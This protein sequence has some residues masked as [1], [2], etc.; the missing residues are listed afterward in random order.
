MTDRPSNLIIRA[1]AGTGK[2]FQLSNRFLE[3][4][5]R[6]VPVDRILATTFTRKAA[7]EILDRVLFRLARAATDKKDREELARFIEIPA[8]GTDECF[9]LL[10]RA[11]RNLH[12]MRVST[13][14][15]FFAQIATS[16]SLELGLPPGW[17]ICEELDDDRMRTQ[18]I[19]TVLGS[20]KEL[21]QLT[22]LL[23]KGE[24][25]RGIHQ[26]VR[27]CVDQLYQL[28]LETEEPAWQ[29]LP[30][31]KPL[32]NVQLAA[33]LDDLRAVALPN[34]KRFTAAR[35]AD[36]ERAAAGD[37]ETFI[38]KGIAA[39]VLDNS[40]QY[41]GKPIPDEVAD[42][43][44]E[45]LHQA[46][47]EIVGR[48]ARQTE[49][50]YQLLD[51]F[52]ESYRQL[53]TG[54]G[55]L[56]FDD[57]TDFLARQQ[58]AGGVD[59]LAFRL[60]SRMDHL[61]LDEFQ[62]TSLAQWQVIR[63][64]AK[65][66]AAMPEGSFFCVGDVK[67]AI[68]GW[69]GGIAEIFDA[70]PRELSD[71]TYG[72][73]DVSYRSAAPVIDTVNAVF[74]TMERHPNLARGENEVRRWCA[75]FKK[76]STARNDL[77]GFARL[78]TSPDPAE[79]ERA[80]D[81]VLAYAAQ[82]VAD[83]TAKAPGFSIGVLVRTNDAV[84]RLI[85]LL[86]KMRVNASEEGGN[87][88]TDS[89]AVRT[90]SSLLKLADHP[91]DTVART[92][93][94]HSPLGRVLE[95]EDA[96]DTAAAVLLSQRVRRRLVEQGYGPAVYDFSRPLLPGCNRREL[97]RLTQ[98]V[99][100]AYGYQSAVTLRPT[101]F[102]RLVE[103]QRV[104]DPTA[105]DVRVMTVHQSKG[106]QF[107][108]VV[109]PDL[110]VDLIGQSGAFVVD[111]ADPISPVRGVCLYVNEHV[112]RLMPQHIQQMFQ[113]A[114]DRAVGESLCVLYVA[115]TRASHALHMIVAPSKTNERKLRRTFAGL[116]R[117]TLADTQRAPA[118]MN[119]YETGDPEWFTRVGQ[120]RAEP[121][122]TPPL[123]AAATHEPLP[124]KLAPAACRQRGL[125]RVSPSG[126]EGGSRVRISS[127]ARTR[128]TAA[129]AARGTLWH[130]WLQH[131]RWLEDGVP[132][133][134]QLRQ[135]AME[136]LDASSTLD[137]QHELSQFRQMLDRPEFAEVLRRTSYRPPL[138]LNTVPG[139]LDQLS[140][141]RCDLHVQTE[142][143]FAIR[144]GNTLLTGSIDRLVLIGHKDNLLAADITDYKTDAIR[145][146]DEPALQ[147]RIDYYR[148]QL[149]AYRRAVSQFSRLAESRI[150]TR[151]VFL[152]SGQTIDL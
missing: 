150:S 72:D 52:H 57:V 135:A 114:T 62:D 80:A 12:R 48:V 151:L 124:I 65:H 7:G 147:S 83:M 126:L 87:P 123:A 13:L 40:L 9:A 109:L 92:H 55:A 91:G 56:R 31:Q 101:D 145:A 46:T 45:L 33:T 34:D 26:L 89:A 60:D 88:L 71:L 2:T 116:L 69:R 37:W 113:A 127:L 50:T 17:R 25:R 84:A 20:T 27:D 144:E 90:V 141:G 53:K 32:S 106:L 66:V 95:F 6:G 120:R 36:Y 19:E 128:E 70:L 54:R 30:K 119:L 15:S 136:V 64:F 94:A 3:L 152:H 122:P 140:S 86:R 98:L 134:T 22:H 29:R 49:G 67:Q 11:V 28:Y 41:H 139:L 14:D 18:A 35:D 5:Q 131:V 63:P 121:P 132:D 8:L 4:L 78:C 138:G 73:L 108:T 61:L 75:R 85:Y 44:R 104:S 118:E 129:A 16:F 59:R 23:T 24:A 130:H 39:K 42:I 58:W 143:R 21:V 38:S 1:S 103:R 102:V 93:V 115:M 112:R 105:A 10:T 146:D 142:R 81:A 137:V 79:G 82:Q 133:D 96:T 125:E 99:E 100:L 43:Y 107:D 76:H 97:N 110:D 51:K 149:A 68:Y 74:M 77:A 117:A 47:A 111:R 148:P